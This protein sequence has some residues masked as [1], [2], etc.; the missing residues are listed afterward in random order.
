MDATSQLVSAG[1]FIRRH[2][3]GCPEFVWSELE[4]R[5]MDEMLPWHEAAGS[6]MRVAGD[7]ILYRSPA[8]S[9]SSLAQLC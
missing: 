6:L 1:S 9:V 3:E 2:N 7:P 5:E 8:F 4:S